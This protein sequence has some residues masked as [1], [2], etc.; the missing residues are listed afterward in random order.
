VTPL[1]PG[2]LAPT[3][4][5]RRVTRAPTGT[6]AA[7]KPLPG[8]GSVLDPRT[9]KQGIEALRDLTTRR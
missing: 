8:T 2:A 4:A 6:R 1:T 9:W 3:R 7:A 5:N